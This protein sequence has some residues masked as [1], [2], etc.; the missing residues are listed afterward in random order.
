MTLGLLSGRGFTSSYT[1]SSYTSS[2][3]CSICCWQFVF[4]CLGC[5]F[6]ST[7]CSVLFDSTFRFLYCLRCHLPLCQHDS[8]ILT[9]SLDVSITPLYLCWKV[10][11]RLPRNKYR[12]VFRFFTTRILL[13]NNYECIY[14]MMCECIHALLAFNMLVW[15]LL[16]LAQ[17]CPN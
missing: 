3:S 4:F 10:A 14:S 12:C 5:C 15:D 6:S 8:A 13:F 1:S 9:A 7:A 11:V 17:A 2:M 16:R